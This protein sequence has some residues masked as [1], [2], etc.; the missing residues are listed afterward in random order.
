MDGC[1]KEGVT[2]EVPRKRGILQ[3]RG[4]GG[5]G[6]G[7]NPGGNYEHFLKIAE[8][9]EPK[10]NVLIA[11]SELFSR[12]IYCL[13]FWLSNFFLKGKHK[14]NVHNPKYIVFAVYKYLL[15]VKN[16][17]IKTPSK[18]IATV[19]L[20]LTLNMYLKKL[21]STNATFTYNSHSWTH[22]QS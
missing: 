8:K 4:G 12:L 16:K 19:P 15:Q 1:Q 7:S 3:K 18:N 17:D 10:N 11:K 21:S 14:V 20:L 22:S 9:K 2:W 13:H 6:W 5:G